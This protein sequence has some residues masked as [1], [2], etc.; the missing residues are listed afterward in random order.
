MFVIGCSGEVQRLWG[1]DAIAAEKV[2]PQPGEAPG[3][4]R[5]AK[6]RWIPLTDITNLSFHQLPLSWLFAAMCGFKLP[7]MPFVG[8]DDL[9]LHAGS[10]ALQLPPLPSFFAARPTVST[11][12]L[13]CGGTDH[14]L[15]VCRG[16]DQGL[17]AGQ[18]CSFSL[19]KYCGQRHLHFVVPSDSKK[20]RMIQFSHALHARG[21]IKPALRMPLRVYSPRST[22]ILY[23]V[24]IE[25]VSF[26]LQ[27]ALE[28][29]CYYFAIVSQRICLCFI[30]CVFV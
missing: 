18:G 13:V 11:W 29:V 14:P 20:I 15:F 25:S 21:T 4:V 1:D 17:R 9:P 16:V 27:L 7:K 23:F 22:L 19:C 26:T 24:F 28:W 30:V 2:K 12:C 5:G 8:V 6:A 10:P 3:V